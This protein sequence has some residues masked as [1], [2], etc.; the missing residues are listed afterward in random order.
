MSTRVRWHDE[1]LGMQCVV[2]GRHIS[3]ATLNLPPKNEKESGQVDDCF[4]YDTEHESCLCEVGE[5]YGVLYGGI[6]G[7]DNQSFVSNSMLVNFYLQSTPASKITTLVFLLINQ[8]SS[9]ES[10]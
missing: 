7:T 1:R 5:L 9:I 2:V 4:R 6:I 8:L 10:A 3:K